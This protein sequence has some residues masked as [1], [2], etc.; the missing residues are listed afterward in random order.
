MSKADKPPTVAAWKKR[1]SEIQKQARY[2]TDPEARG[3]LQASLTA[4]QDGL[5]EAQRA[6][7]A[8]P[9]YVTGTNLFSLVELVLVHHGKTA[10]PNEISSTSRAHI[11]RCMEGGLIEPAGKNLHLTPAGRTAVADEIISRINREQQY[12][13]REDRAFSAEAFAKD[14]ER[15]KAK[16]AKLEG[17][18]ANLA[19]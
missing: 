9:N 18:L 6:A 13:P 3:V 10:F 5:R 16:L 4:A 7:T 1:I 17:A 2:T 8:S 12:P 11:K 15:H 14:V 19:R